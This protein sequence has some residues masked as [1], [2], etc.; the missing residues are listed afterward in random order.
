MFKISAK[1]ILATFLF[2]MDSTVKGNALQAETSTVSNNWKPSTD[3]FWFLQASS[4]FLNTLP[5]KGDDL[6]CQK[7]AFD[8]VYREN[9]CGAPDPD[10]YMAT[11]KSRYTCENRCGNVPSYGRDFF[12]CACDESCIAHGDCCRDI[13]VACPEIYARGQATYSHFADNLI[14]ICMDGN[15]NT[16]YKAYFN[17]KYTKE[18]Y[19]T[20]SKTE[21]PN[22]INDRQ[23]IVG[24][25]L[26]K[27]IMMPF[28]LG[29]F[30]LKVIFDSFSTFRLLA[31]PT[32]IPF[33]IPKTVSLLCPLVSLKFLTSA[34]QVFSSCNVDAVTD[35]VTPLHRN[36]EM[37]EIMSCHCESDMLY[38]QHVHNV[39]MG[40]NG[41]I[42]SLYTL[43][44]YQTQFVFSPRDDAQCSVWNVTDFGLYYPDN[45]GDQKEG[46]IQIKVAAF[47][48]ELRSKD[49]AYSASDKAR[50]NVKH[51]D[52]NSAGISWDTISIEDIYY[53]VELE[54]T[55]E[56]R[57]LCSTLDM[58]LTEC[59]LEECVHGSIVS[60]A[61]NAL[62]HFGNRSCVIPAVADVLVSGSNR[63]VP[64]CSC[65]RVMAALSALRIWR[66]KW[67]TGGISGC[68][69]LTLPTKV[70]ELKESSSSSTLHFSLT[71]ETRPSLS[72][73]FQNLFK[74]NTTNCLDDEEAIGNALQV[75]LYTTIEVS[76]TEL[77]PAM[78]F[79]TY[80]EKNLGMGIVHGHAEVLLLS[81]K[82]TII[83]CFVYASPFF[84][85]NQL[86]DNYLT[87]RSAWLQSGPWSPLRHAP[88]NLEQKLRSSRVEFS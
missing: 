68:Y 43:Y 64:L 40:Q 11:Y 80:A 14:R 35:V 69:F 41:P 34:S 31:K 55:K 17:D 37:K 61:G 50:A 78:C 42:L 38:K 63:T 82:F 54:D 47:F 30:S 27:D 72:T 6:E 44:F 66:I 2:G 86:R 3:D 33:F 28:K 75:C 79:P 16:F 21:I 24:S 84:F 71:E 57:L 18:M 19:P 74:R 22:F 7:I 73:R 56:K 46:A 26:L 52:E 8:Y 36:C 4:S 59:K 1:F 81:S 25:R 87:E 32:S 20:T 49:K 88:S 9:V 10:T 62:G 53:V 48:R 58:P 83:I 85:F 29:D 67:A 51:A 12:I 45:G 13:S 70:D 76:N 65:L 39:C 15:F 5:Q 23:T 77:K 60:D